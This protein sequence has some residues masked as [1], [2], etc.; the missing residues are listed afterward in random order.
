MKKN[1]WKFAAVLAA[2]TLAVAFAGCGGK[3]KNIPV[4]SVT[5]NL[6]TKSLVTVRDGAG[7]TLTAEVLPANASQRNVTWSVS[8]DEGA[9]ELEGAGPSVTVKPLAKGTTYITAKADGVDSEPCTVTVT[10]ED[11]YI[12]VTGVSLDC[13]DEKELKIGNTLIITA[14]FDPGNATIQDVTWEIEQEGSFI[15]ELGKGG[16][17]ITVKGL[18]EGEALVKVTAEDGGK[19]ASASIAVTE[20][21][22][23]GK[24]TVT[25]HNNGG[26]SVPSLTVNTNESIDEPE[27]VTG[28]ATELKEGIYLEGWYTEPGFTAKWDF[29]TDKVTADTDL[30]ARWF[31]KLSKTE[32]RRIGPDIGPAP[33][34]MK[35]V[36]MAPM[37]NG[38]LDGQ[39][40][41]GMAIDPN[42]TGILYLTVG[43][44]EEKK[45]KSGIMKSTDRGM[46]WEWMHVMFTEGVEG[47]MPV[48]IRVDPEDPGRLYIVEM[49]KTKYGLKLS[50]D[51][52]A[53]FAEHP[54]WRAFKQANNLQ[55]DLYHLMLDPADSKHLLVTTKGPWS[56]WGDKG[57]GAIESTNGGAAWKGINRPAG[58]KD[59]Y[60]WNTWFLRHP[61][62]A[63]SNSGSDGKRWLFAT[64][65]I[66]G[67]DPSNPPKEEDFGTPAEYDAALADFNE[68]VANANTRGYYLTENGGGSW[69]HVIGPTSTSNINMNMEHGGG[70]V[71]YDEGG[72]LYTAGTSDYADGAQI[73][74]STDNGATWLPFRNGLKN[75]ERFLVI[76]GYGSYL[77]TSPH[78]DNGAEF[79]RTA[80]N[81]ANWAKMN[82]NNNGA[83]FPYDE[84]QGGVFEYVVDPANKILYASC[85]GS[86]VYALQLE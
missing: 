62:P 86:G 78:N 81:S 55:D 53:T 28:P 45:Y 68:R 23:T 43:S 13:G 20:S 31:P 71:Y 2:I 70:N 27:N 51:G 64:Q 40:H 11:E 25:F 34:G 49:I 44:H 5:L 58:L 61:N 65:G 1:L 19:K 33:E 32:W 52:G 35:Y 66:D 30:Y 57:W 3:K 54:G 36:G 85:V 82:V 21:G 72:V 22:G 42:N 12:P 75:H 76:T 10:P 39:F 37:P 24:A 38:F 29:A 79:Y 59:G 26:S 7:F 9:V 16:L 50:T 4:T 17:T 73:L 67:P 74:K 56:G 46:T 47:Q 48:N 6:Y 15:E 69:T 84:M 80:R 63:A 60:G 18:A 83:V 41:Q 14:V 77:Y 8:G